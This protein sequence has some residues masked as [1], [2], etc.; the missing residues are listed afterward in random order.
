[1]RTLVIA[2][3]LFCALAGIIAGIELRPTPVRWCCIQSFDSGFGVCTREGH[4]C[5]THRDYRSTS[6]EQAACFDRRAILRDD[7]QQDCNPTMTSCEQS[8]ARALEN[9]EYDRVSECRALDANQHARRMW[10]AEVAATLLGAA[11]LFVGIRYYASWAGRRRDDRWR[12]KT[13]G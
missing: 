2:G 8:R 1:M 7:N 12:R 6:Q 3:G 4:E 5:V 9:R 11:G 13:L 10:Y